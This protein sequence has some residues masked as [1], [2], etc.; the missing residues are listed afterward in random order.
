ML[1]V[2]VASHFTGRP[3]FFDAHSTAL[4]RER[5]ALQPEAAADIRRH[6]ADLALG[7]WKMSDSS[8]RTPCGF[9]E[10]V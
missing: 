10:E 1:S 2:R 5:A 9:W 8:M 4:V 7:A 6:H 3:S